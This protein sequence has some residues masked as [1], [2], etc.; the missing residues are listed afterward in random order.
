MLKFKLKA[1]FLALDADGD[2][3]IS[4]KEMDTLLKS[5]KSKLRMSESEIRKLIR[6]VDQN[7]D[8]KVDV[9]EFFKMIE[10]GKKRDVIYKELVKRSGIR[11]SFQKYDVN[12]D[13]VITRDEFRRIVEAKYQT[14]MM[15]GQIDTLMDKVDVNQSG[16]ID[17]EEFYKAFT[18]FPAGK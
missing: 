2:G 4:I 5:V 15:P 13:G 11:Q 1:E 8:G 12:G 9:Q 7:G 16:M 10:C 3:D 14:K 17:Y 18:Y 6:E